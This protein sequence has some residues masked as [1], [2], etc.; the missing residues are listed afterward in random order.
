MNEVHYRPLGTPLKS[1]ISYFKTSSWHLRA[2]PSLARPFWQ[3]LAVPWSILISW[4]L[5]SSQFCFLPPSWWDPWALGTRVARCSGSDTERFLESNMISLQLAF[6]CG[7]LNMS[8]P[9]DVGLSPHQGGKDQ[10][11]LEASKVDWPE[12]PVLPLLNSC[13][14]E[15]DFDFNK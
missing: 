5:L 6:L 7:S 9:F 11:R 2:T 13:L 8:K 10:A 12:V 15:L 4:K 3:C 1:V 14:A